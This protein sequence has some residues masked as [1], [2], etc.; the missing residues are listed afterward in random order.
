VTV[1]EVYDITHK[2]AR[3]LKAR[4][5]GDERWT[6]YATAPARTKLAVQPTELACLAPPSQRSNEDDGGA[7]VVL[8]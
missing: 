2:A 4:L 3:L 1:A 8:R 6:G 7:G 5:E